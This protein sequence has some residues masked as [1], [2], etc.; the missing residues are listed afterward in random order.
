[1][2][3]YF[4]RTAVGGGE[5]TGVCRGP[6]GCRRSSVPSGDGGV[7]SAVSVKSFLKWSYALCCDFR[8]AEREGEKFLV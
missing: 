1:M 4:S 2:H 7:A 3:F 5:S 6:S 8:C